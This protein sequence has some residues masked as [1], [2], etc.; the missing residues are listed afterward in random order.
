MFSIIS[1]L[2]INSWT[3]DYKKIINEQQII[4]TDIEGTCLKLGKIRVENPVVKEADGAIE[5]L[6]PNEA[7]LRNL[8]YSAPLFLE[9]TV[10]KE[11]QDT[12]D[13]PIEANIG[14][15]PIMLK[16]KVCNLVDMTDEEKNLGRRRSA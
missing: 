10:V 8:S 6:H 16:S 7:R 5:R 13:E 1:I 3:Q 15:L 12:Q 14:Q 4:E 9:M 11:G 2:S